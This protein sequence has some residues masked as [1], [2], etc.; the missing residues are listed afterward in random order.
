MLACPFDSARLGKERE[1]FL[2]LQYSIPGSLR[3]FLYG[4]ISSL[5]EERGEG[6]AVVMEEE[7][8]RMKRVG[9]SQVE[10]SYP[11]D[12]APYQRQ[13]APVRRTAGGVDR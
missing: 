12:A 11:S 8:R 2:K 5:C 13:W 9:D 3:T 4:E 10:Q 6:G 1:I 7:Q